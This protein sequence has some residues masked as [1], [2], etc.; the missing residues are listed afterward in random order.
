MTKSL[1]KDNQNHYNEITPDLLITCINSG[2]AQASIVTRDELCDIIDHMDNA[3]D[4][5][6]ILALL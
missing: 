6:F 1:L 2:L 5:F 3:C 4:A